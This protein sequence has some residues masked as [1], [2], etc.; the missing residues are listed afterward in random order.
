VAEPSAGAGLPTWPTYH[1]NPART[2]VATSTPPLGRL[3]IA[4]RAALGPVYAQPLVVDGLLIVATESDRVMALTPSTGRVVWKT[5][6]GSPVPLSRLPCGNIDPSGVTGTPVY[7]ATT[8]TVFAVAE[9]GGTNQPIHHVLVAVAA[10]S[11]KIRWR[12]SIDPAGSDPTVQQERAALALSSGRV[13]VAL[14]GLDGDCG[15]YRGYVV[16]APTSGVGSLRTYAVPS[17]HKAGIWAA[18]GPAVDAAGDIYVSVGNGTSVHTW[19]GSNS[20]L[21]LAPTLH[22]LSYFAESSWVNDNVNDTDLGSSGPVLLPGGEVVI[23]GKSGVAYL[24]EAGRLG[25]I[26]HPISRLAG[27]VSFGGLAALSAEVYLPCTG[28]LRALVVSHGSALRW[29][30]QDRG[31]T[32]S[33]VIGGGVVWSLRPAAGT[34]VAV[35]PST[36]ARR[37]DLAV[38]AASRFASPT[39]SAGYVFVPTLAGVTAVQGA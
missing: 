34:L 7:D 37:A 20:V 10:R 33:P 2:G 5:T 12:R 3:R 35:S 16:T 14:G 17:P 1:A 31:L 38:G 23:A 19:D 15:P 6:V 22:V 36:G 27:C 25:G 8:D 26:G 13:V 21:E 29:A 28:G 24:L 11:G 39:L 4:W 32:G 30:W 9:T 18:S